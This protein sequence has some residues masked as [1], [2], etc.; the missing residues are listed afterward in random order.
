MLAYETIA[1]LSRASTAAEAEVRRLEVAAVGTG[2]PLGGVLIPS[3]AQ[4]AASAARATFDALRELR[5]AAIESGDEAQ[6]AE[7]AASL[8]RIATP[9]RV[10]ESIKRPELAAVAPRLLP[11][12]VWVLVG[13]VVLVLLAPYATAAAAL[14][15]RRRTA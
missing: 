1:R 10:A 12:W 8:E 3:D 2:G 15:A 14:A 6:A 9:G 4:R 11:W 13:L 5:D 7:V